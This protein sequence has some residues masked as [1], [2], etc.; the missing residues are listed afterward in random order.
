LLVLIEW[1]YNYFTHNRGARLITGAPCADMG[2]TSPEWTQPKNLGKG[3]NSAREESYFS[4]TGDSKYIYFESYVKD[5]VR[6][7]FRADL[8]E[9][10]KPASTLDGAITVSNTQKSTLPK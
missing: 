7:L 9:S 1:A 5:G 10:V 6:D 4:I 2:S 8:P 3:I